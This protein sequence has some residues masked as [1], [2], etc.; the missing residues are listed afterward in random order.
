MAAMSSRER[1]TL[2]LNHKEPDRVPVDLISIASTIRTVEAYGRLKNYLA[3]A[4]D[5]KIRER[6]DTLK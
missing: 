1:F 3:L 5:K 6:G 4:V 2:A